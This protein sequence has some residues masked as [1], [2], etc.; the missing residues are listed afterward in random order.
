MV[1]LIK[2][3]LYNYIFNE[4][5]LILIPNISYKLILL[6]KLVSVFAQNKGSLKYSVHYSSKIIG[7]KS[8]IIIENNCSKVL[9]SFAV[10][11][12]C[13]IAVFSNSKLQIGENT[14]FAPNICIQTAN[15]DSFNR[16][17][18]H[19]KDVIIGKNCWIGYGVVIL[20]GVVIG[21]NVT[22]G[23]NSVVNKSFT[24]NVV[25]AGVPAK[26]IKEL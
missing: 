26:I 15:H 10:S 21:D 24:D 3:F 14:I 19:E 25:I 7:T 18:Y 9:T 6:N 1:N 13:Y 17:L 8:N 16:D 23:A 22:I 5:E 2:K 11:G 20:P 4:N 12:S